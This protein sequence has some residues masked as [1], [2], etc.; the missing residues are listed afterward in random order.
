M[1]FLRELVRRYDYCSIIRLSCQ[2]FGVALIVFIQFI[3]QVPIKCVAAQPPTISEFVEGHSQLRADAIGV[4]GEYREFYADAVHRHAFEKSP[5]DIGI[6][7]LR[8]G[9]VWRSSER[10]RVDFRQYQHN[11][12]AEKEIQYA[13]AFDSGK[14][15]EFSRGI[16]PNP[17]IL[18]V[19][20]LATAEAETSMNSIEA[21]FLRNLD[22][23]WS[24]DKGV[25]Y[26]DLLQRP[27]SKIVSSK[28][29]FLSGGYAI[30]IPAAEGSGEFQ[31]EFEPV[32]KFP[33]GYYVV[34][35]EAGDIRVRAERRV[36]SDES[37]GVLYP[38]RL[39][40][41]T[42]F[43]DGRG[44]TKV[45]ELDLEPLALESPIT[46]DFHSASFRNH[47]SGYQVYYTKATADEKLGERYERLPAEV[48]A[49][50]NNSLRAYFLWING[51]V[52][53]A[54]LAYLIY[55][56]WRKSALA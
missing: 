42:S 26:V 27:G 21:F 22:A 43:G 48:V 33:F 16:G 8:S 51:S 9:Y 37:E 54:L 28:S 49:N 44:F 53:L 12:A 36:F 35:E 55:R 45:V 25:G 17:G 10:F 18:R 41:V 46:R 31:A 2:G 50:S 4:Q 39:V 56:Y 29:G 6:P 19:F 30:Q 1:L 24:T 40:E 14:V 20:D 11:E 52:A 47:E 23:L 34:T 13:Y 32:A 3:A 5:A 7:L 38:T 15:Y